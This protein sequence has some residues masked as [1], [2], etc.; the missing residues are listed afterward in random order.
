[1]RGAE[2]DNVTYGTVT[3]INN[4]S[5][6][7][8]PNNFKLYQNY[9]NPFNPS[10]V[11][12]WQS[13]VLSLATIKIFDML[14]KEIAI[15]MDEEKPAGKYKLEFDAGKYNLSSGIYLI[16]LKLKKGGKEIFTSSKKITMI[17]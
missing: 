10:T 16:N 1:M 8:Y 17:K 6:N 15:L 13:S 14:G 2:I 5:N 11:I 9:P 4:Y 7:A 3:S 12:S